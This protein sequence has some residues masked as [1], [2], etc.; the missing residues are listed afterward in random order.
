M[1]LLIYNKNTNV[2]LQYKCI[3]SITIK[4][5]LLNYKINTSTQLQDKY[6]E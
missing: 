4:I 6:I 5:H 2:Q 3:Y 1:L